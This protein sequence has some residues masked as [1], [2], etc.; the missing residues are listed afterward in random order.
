MPLL[1]PRHA[2]NKAFLKVKPTRT[3]I[4]IFKSQLKKLLD[5]RNDQ[6]SEEFHKNLISGFLQNTAFTG[7]PLKTVSV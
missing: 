3:Q 6:E 1:T 5:H 4:D 2:L 7:K